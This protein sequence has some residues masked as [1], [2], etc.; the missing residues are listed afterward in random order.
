MKLFEIIG[1]LLLMSILIPRLS[2]MAFMGIVDTQKRQAADHLGLIS[3]AS[4]GYVRKH[5]TTLNAQASATSGPMVSVADLV[6]DGLLPDG[7][8]GRNVWGQSY[9]IY[10]R[11]AAVSGHLRAV[12]LTTGGRGNETDRFL[13]VIVP[14]AAGLL[15]GSGGFVPTGI[16][17]GQA[18]D[19]LQG[20]G[21]GWA[22]SLTG[23]GIP[24]P[25]PG[26]LG[27]LTSFDS[28]ALGQ[29]FLYRVAVPGHPEL[30]AMQTELDMTDHAIRN[31]SELQFEEREISGESCASADEQGRVFLDR[32]Q[33]LY[34]CRNNSLELI[35][36]SGNSTL[37]KNVTVAKNGDRITKPVCAPGTG[38]APAVF[39][40]PSIAEAGP[41]APPLTSFQ[42]WATSLSDTA[43]Q[44]HMRVQTGNKRL[45]GSDDEGW[46][47]PAD[48][49]G[50]I[51]VLA[52]C[53]KQPETP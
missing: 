21:G 15:G 16:V 9:D 27:V 32:V 41:E 51:M 34:L 22:V 24:S 8:K 47:Y 12:V 45:D 37:L 10:V 1:V 44:V 23:M 33:G 52:M 48:D 13:N 35:G 36:D 50:R 26:H 42:T 46:V 19:I 14:G 43:W 6:S 28:T 29:D 49:Y 18:A 30:N 25:G 17:P 7:F 20:A 39:T 31:V 3:R 53:I 4:A 11:K 2:D 40:S 38:T 5:Q